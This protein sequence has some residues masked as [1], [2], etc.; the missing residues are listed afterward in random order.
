MLKKARNLNNFL[1]SSHYSSYSA[2]PLPQGDGF[3]TGKR[4]PEF[5]VRIYKGIFPTGAG[6]N[7][8]TGLPEAGN[9]RSGEPLWDPDSRKRD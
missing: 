6:T 9:R 2:K 1:P 8:G 7:V 4:K 3:K 5:R